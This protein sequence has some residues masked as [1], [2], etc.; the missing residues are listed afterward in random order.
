MLWEIGV[1]GCEV[2][3]LRSRL[4]LDS[5]YLSR[6]LRALESAGL[7]VVVPAPRDRR[8]RFAQLTRKGIRERRTLDR[9]S[10][11]LAA[12]M[13]TSLEKKQQTQ[14][15]D[16][17]RTVERLLVSEA[18]DIRPIDPASG[19]ARYCIAS[20]FAELDRR[21]GGNFDPAAAIS[22]EPHELVE[23][24]GC[25]VVAWLH[26]EPIGCG[27]VKFHPGEAT[28]IKRMW[29]AESA[30]GLGVGRK[31]LVELEALA[32]RSGATL[33]HIETNKTLVEA[34]AMYVS[35]GYVE[36][37]AFNEEPFADHWFEKRL[38]A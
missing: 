4:E 16:A 20:Y 7:V 6:V 18:V 21:S 31:L 27:A 38:V 34:I 26:D 9:R 1:E 22:A 29:V 14:L 30:R 13:L 12:S 10:D 33:A 11:D 17:M 35:A 36:V 15:V 2:R 3:A 5:G 25:M 19:V 32:M 28:E 23:P 24:H 8:I 37:P